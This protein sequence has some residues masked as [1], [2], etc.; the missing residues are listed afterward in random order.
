MEQYKSTEGGIWVLQ[1]QEKRALI[2]IRDSFQLY[3][4]HKIAYAYVQSV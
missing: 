1:Q 3:T 4:L 2:G